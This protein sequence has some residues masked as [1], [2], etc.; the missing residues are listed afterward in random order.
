MALP[1]LELEL[2]MEPNR[3]KGGSFDLLSRPCVCFFAWLSADQGHLFVVCVRNEVKQI[4]FFFVGM[5]CTF[6]FDFAVYIHLLDIE[7]GLILHLKK[8]RT[9]T[10]ENPVNRF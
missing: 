1:A 8:A 7:A 2:S 9:T 4:S 5:V 3:E 10:R 6:C